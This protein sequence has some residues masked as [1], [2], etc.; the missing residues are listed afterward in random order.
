MLSGPIYKQVDNKLSQYIECEDYSLVRVTR[1]SR[2]DYDS[3]FWTEK[4]HDSKIRIGKFVSIAQKCN[5]LL[6]GNHNYKNVTTYLPFE[7]EKSDLHLSSNGDI[8]IGHDVWIGMDC[9]IMSG[10]KI[11]TGSVLAAGSVVV[12]DV[13]PYSIIG[14]NPAK[15]IK[16]RF[17]Q[18]TIERLLESRWWDIPL[19]KLK[20]ISK[21]LF[22]EDIENFIQIINHIS[23]EKRS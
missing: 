5:F 16:K 17:D 15:V 6:G 4:H 18:N 1:S 10:I 22:S 8:E 21:D 12:K 9:T 14:G 7:Y 20:G 23:N 11:G 3:T 2:E 13:E 19:E